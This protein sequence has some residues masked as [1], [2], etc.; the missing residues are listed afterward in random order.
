MSR[1]HH[2]PLFLWVAT[3]ALAHL[4]W[5]GG[6]NQ[7]AKL[8]EAQLDVTR[9]AHQVDGFFGA[10]AGGD[11]ELEITLLDPVEPTPSPDP[12][13]EVDDT[14]DPDAEEAPTER[15]PKRPDKAKPTPEPDPEPKP[16]KPKPV[17]KQAA[18]P[19]PE[20][21]KPKAPEEA[22][23]ELPK[24]RQ[25]VA[26]QQHQEE[27]E[28]DENA[29]AEFIAEKAR[30]V[31]DQSQARITATDRNEADP[32]PGGNHTSAADNPGNADQTSV[33]QS[34]DAPGEMAQ[35]P[36][37]RATTPK[38][39]ESQGAAP[40]AAGEGRDLTAKRQADDEQ[41]PGKAQGEEK[42]KSRSERASEK[43]PEQRGSKAVVGAPDMTSGQSGDEQVAPGSKP[44]LAKRGKRARP[45]R[46]PPVKSK[47][48]L[49]GFG[50]GGTTKDGVN[51][52]LHQEMAAD[53]LGRGELDRLRRLDGER[54]RS[55]HRG[56]WKSVGME[57]WRPAIENYVAKVKPGNQ[58]ALNTA[59]VPFARYL[60]EI[61][62]R[63]HPVFADSFLGSLSRLP[64]DHAMNKSDLRT[65]L[66][67]IL[68]SS[69]G[70]LVDMGVTRSS[71][72]TAFDVAALESV[73]RAQPFGAPPKA[74]ISPDGN[75]YLHW[76]FYRD[77]W[78]A[79][80][81]YFARPYILKAAPD[82]RPPDIDAPKFGPREDATGFFELFPRRQRA[83]ND[84]LFGFFFDASPAHPH[85]HAHHDHAH[86]DHSHHGH[87]HH[88]RSH[89]GHGHPED[90]A[91]E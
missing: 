83:L 4:V 28:E 7:A 70:R 62:N 47:S 37:D 73:K 6:A 53:M 1:E 48:R 64:G 51:L 90:H 80:S 22:P 44:K 58:T 61:H 25:R 56:S 52:N 66:E 42:S 9:F 38:P 23:L 20:E 17:V 14:P 84:G 75:V 32:N 26:V 11:D 74:I 82:S 50:A 19:K 57:R 71:G 31:K 5:G 76:E 59:R 49:L 24:P 85:D 10:G 60:N 89:H 63:L 87:A 27:D 40:R 16:P 2:I 33:K 30:K 77:P 12:D 36:N 88:D 21:E 68:S 8:I 13:A 46:L 18:E 55:T 86:H 39:G 65:N 45:K 3:A 34:E 81:T 29:D 69:D 54:R 41:R 15:D 78:Y 79:C 43:T 72:V 91:A 67:I 35:A